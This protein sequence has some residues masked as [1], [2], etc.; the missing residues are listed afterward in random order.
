MKT[1]VILFLVPAF[2]NN[3]T[4]F[5]I[6]DTFSVFLVSNDNDFFTLPKDDNKF[7]SRPHFSLPWLHQSAY[8]LCYYFHCYAL[9]SLMFIWLTLIQN[10]TH[11]V[12]DTATSK[13][14]KICVLECSGC[15]CQLNLQC[16]KFFSDSVLQIKQRVFTGPYKWKLCRIKDIKQQHWLRPA[17]PHESKKRKDVSLLSR[18]K[19]F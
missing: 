11:F 8:F 9:L 19:Q 14:I 16:C 18:E 5:F 1:Q 17:F 3:A 10:L 4:T 2:L 15:S 6:S 13:S 7:A 12:V